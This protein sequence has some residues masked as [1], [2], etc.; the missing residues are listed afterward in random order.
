MLLN[1]LLCLVTCENN[2]NISNDMS[3]SSDIIDR[4]E[5]PTY[6]HHMDPIDPSETVYHHLINHTTHQVQSQT[7]R[8][9]DSLISQLYPR[10]SIHLESIPWLNNEEIGLGDDLF[11]QGTKQLQLLLI[12]LSRNNKPLALKFLNTVVKSIFSNAYIHTDLSISTS[13]ETNISNFIRSNLSSNDNKSKTCR[14]TIAHASIFNQSLS[15]A[16][17][18]EIMKVRLGLSKKLISKVMSDETLPFQF[19]D[20]TQSPSELN[21]LQIDSI[22]EFCHNDE[23]SRIDSNSN[24]CVKVRINNVVQ[25]HPGRV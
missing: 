6:V 22:L 24:H 17:K 20:Y 13:I 1:C 3:Q 14:Y 7:Q 18:K 2:T 9:F 10:K 15:V 11:R 5:D 19:P 12:V 23:C 25:K 8:T 16:Q 21:K 4:Y